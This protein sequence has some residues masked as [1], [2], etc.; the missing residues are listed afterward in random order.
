M[1]QPLVLL[2]FG[3]LLHRILPR[4]AW[5]RGKP[6]PGPDVAYAYA[7]CTGHRS[8]VECL[9]WYSPRSTLESS[10]SHT[11]PCSSESKL[12]YIEALSGYPLPPRDYCL[13]MKQRNKT[14]YD[15]VQEISNPLMELCT[16]TPR[17]GV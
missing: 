12:V 14:N 16:P 10:R 15:Q 7:Y 9:F 4:R 13:E 5:R 1:T 2:H 11:A 17:H 6:R 3:M 8:L